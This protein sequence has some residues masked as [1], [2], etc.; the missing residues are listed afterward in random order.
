MHNPPMPPDRLACRRTVASPAPSSCSDR[1]GF[2]SIR[3]RF[4]RERPSRRPAWR[5]DLAGELIASG[6]TAPRAATDPMFAELVRFRRTIAKADVSTISTTTTKQPEL[7][8]AWRL[9][10]QDGLPRWVLEARLLAGQSTEAIAKLQGLS[11][12]V[13]EAY[14]AAFFDVADRLGSTLWV[15]RTVFGPDYLSRLEGRDVGALLRAFCYYTGPIGLDALLAHAV[16]ADGRLRPLE[17]G[18]LETAEARTA[19][20]VQVAVVSMIGSSEPKRLV[21]LTGVRQLISD[22]EHRFSAQTRARTAVSMAA[23]ALPE[24][25][26]IATGLDETIPAQDPCTRNV[27]SEPYMGP[28]REGG[29]AGQDKDAA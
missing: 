11:V 17:I 9:R 27:T 23:T 10:E 12:P 7:F 16:D 21:E 3:L 26:F 24:E 18:N 1:R 29:Q 5:W 8:E 14:Q 28:N 13:I 20:R 22:A 2:S 15:L 19:A 4:A 6:L 25:F